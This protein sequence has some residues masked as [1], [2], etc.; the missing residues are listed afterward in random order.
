MI[1]LGLVASLLGALNP[2]ILFFTNC[3]APCVDGLVAQIPT[4]LGGLLG[5]VTCFVCNAI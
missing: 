2:Q 3:L 5:G 4:L 1:L